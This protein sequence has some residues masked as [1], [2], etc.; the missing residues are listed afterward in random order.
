MLSKIEGIGNFR[1]SDGTMKEID[2]S[3]FIESGNQD[4]ERHVSKFKLLHASDLSSLPKRQYLVKNILDMGGMSVLYGA[5]N[6][7]KTF[8]AI[9]IACHI[10]LGWL[11]RNKKTKVGGIIYVAAE[12]GLGLGE[13]VEAFKAHNNLKGYPNIHVIPESV[14]LS[15]DHNDLDDFLGAIQGVKGVKLIVL[16]TLARVM[17]GGDENSARDI[18][19]FVTLCDKIRFKTKAHVMIVHH[20]GKDDTRGARGSSALKAA[21]DTEIKVSQTE[22]GIIEVKTEKQRDGRTGDVYCFKLS[23]YE[24]DK[25][26]D[27]DPVISCALNIAENS[28]RKKSLNGSAEKARLCLIDLILEA[29][30]YQVPRKGMTAQKVVRLATF[31]EHFIKAGISESDKP[32]SINKAFGRAKNKLK[33]FGYIGE[34]DG[35][36]WLIDKTDKLRQTGNETAQ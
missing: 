29:G 31:K 33:D 8:V 20:S 26:E 4:H 35:Y 9:D 3:D 5:S 10:A 28:S 30:V 21:V 11:W 15:G 24:V 25:D 34:W 16:D 7:G 6:S 36:V 23:E 32:D 17:S 1:N 13:R 14:L 19:E 18:S 12:G 22:G 2:M 27:G